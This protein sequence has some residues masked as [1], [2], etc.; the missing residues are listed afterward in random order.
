M[1]ADKKVFLNTRLQI[2]VFRFC[3]FVLFLVDVG[4]R[5]Q[6]GTSASPS[7]SPSPAPDVAS[8]VDKEWNANAGFSAVLNSGNSVNQTFGGNALVSRKWNKNQVTSTAIGAY[9]RAKSASSGLTETNTKNWKASLRYDRFIRAPLSLFAAS[10]IGEDEPAGF[11]LR[12][13]GATGVS[14]VFL[15]SEADAFKYEA[16]Y[17]FTR[18]D[19]VAPLFD[20]NIHSGRLFLQYQ[21]RFSSWAQFKQDVENLINLEDSEDVRINTLTSLTMKLTTKL[22][23]QTG[24]GV[25]FDN[26][27]VTGF[28]KTDTTTQAGLVFSFL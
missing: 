26:Q 21:H 13:G 18:E 14:H 3:L 20:D 24:F 11:D 22:A 8:K 23:F 5:A 12:Y 16:G 27:P 19:R 17:D 4:L 28:K 15:E 10:H 1:L 2:T 9:G 25:R 7:P 6:D